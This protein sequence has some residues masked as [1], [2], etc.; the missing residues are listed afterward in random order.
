[1]VIIIIFII[2]II[3]FFLSFFLSFFLF[4]FIYLFIFVERPR[5]HS[6]APYLISLACVSS[7]THNLQS[8]FRPGGY[9][10]IQD[11]KTAFNPGNCSGKFYAIITTEGGFSVW[12][13][14]AYRWNF[15]SCHRLRSSPSE[16]VYKR[17]SNGPNTDPWG[18]PNLSG[19]SEEVEPSIWT[20]W[21]GSVR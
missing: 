21:E 15:I 3:I 8:V 4:L 18:T 12:V 2:I 9:S 20:N 19:W 13:L 5:P 6:G 1:M 11:S 17:Y 14:S 16:A 7:A 10:L